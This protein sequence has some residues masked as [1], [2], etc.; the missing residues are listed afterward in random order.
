MKLLLALSLFL[1][2]GRIIIMVPIFSKDL[3]NENG[4][5]AEVGCIWPS[6]V[7]MRGLVPLSRGRCC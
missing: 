7:A 5:L 2:R 4:Q 3:G 6:D 1:C